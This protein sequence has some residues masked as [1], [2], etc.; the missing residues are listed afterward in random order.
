MQHAAGLE[1]A[2]IVAADR[3]DQQVILVE[4]AVN[5]R[6]HPAAARQE[7]VPF[8]GET[9]QQRAVGVDVAG[10]RAADREI[11]D[12]RIEQGPERV[13]IVGAAREAPGRKGRR[14]RAA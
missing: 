7:C 8:G 11:V 9:G 5:R 3:D 10:Q 13:D 2:G 12:R 6:E 1:E 4:R 14:E